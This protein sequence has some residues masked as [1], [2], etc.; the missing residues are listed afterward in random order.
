M[1]LFAEIEGA[2]TDDIADLL[3]PGYGYHV[4]MATAA[5]A[6]GTIVMM[7]GIYLMREN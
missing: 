4:I 3:S 5:A 1:K 2:G 7:I 6:M